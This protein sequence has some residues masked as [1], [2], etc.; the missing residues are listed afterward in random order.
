MWASSIDDMKYEI[1]KVYNLMSLV[2]ADIPV[3][4]I[5]GNHEA[6][7]MYVTVTVRIM[8]KLFTNRLFLEVSLQQI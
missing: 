6:Q 7:N 5:L 2:F 4:P 8:L 3:Y 1:E